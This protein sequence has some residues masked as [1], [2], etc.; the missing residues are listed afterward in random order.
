MHAAQGT[1]DYKQQHG[2]RRQ[3]NRSFSF[4]GHRIFSFLE[5]EL[6]LTNLLPLYLVDAVFRRLAA[7]IPFGVVPS[8]KP[9]PLWG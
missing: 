1:D 9:A 8:Q 4:H 2:K 6:L 7:L 5:K 3:Q